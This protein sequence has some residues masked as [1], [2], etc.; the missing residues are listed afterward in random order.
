MT[1]PSLVE[2]VFLSPIGELQQTEHM[3][4][5]IWYFDKSRDLLLRITTK[6]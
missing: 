1:A 3:I 6:N 5:F 2:L 4:N